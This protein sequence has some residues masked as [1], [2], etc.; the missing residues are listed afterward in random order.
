MYATRASDVRHVVVD[1]RVLMQY[2]SLR[3]L[4]ERSVVERARAEAV[5]VA[6]RAG[7]AIAP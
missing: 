5:K 7:V 4:D 3:T 6:A 2:R 1:G